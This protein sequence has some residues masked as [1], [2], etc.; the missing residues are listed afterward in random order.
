VFF[1]IIKVAALQHHAAVPYPL[2]LRLGPM[3]ARAAADAARRSIRRH[4]PRRTKMNASSTTAS[5]ECLICD[6]DGVLVDSE[7]I[8]DRVLL[9]M[10]GETFT[11][12][13][14]APAVKLSFGQQTDRFVA[15]LA[16]SFGLTIPADFLA[17][18]QV[19]VDDELRRAVEPIDGVRAA[20]EQV[21]LPLAV[22][23]NSGHER[24][25]ISLER[26]GLADLFGDRIFSA[27]DVA[28]PKPFPDVYLHAA[29]TLGASPAR[30]LV[31]EDS[32]AGLSAART[33]GM[34]TIAFIGAAH[35][36]PGY[37]EQ[38][39]D[40]GIGW[41]ID[42]MNALPPLTEAAMRGVFPD[43]DA[44]N[45]QGAADA[46]IAVSTPDRAERSRY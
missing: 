1:R 27:E 43:V 21:R 41:I 22:A 9:Q 29:R 23:S 17:R 16:N 20:L 28:N 32:V 7:A 5:V 15:N 37:R 42:R 18:L 31:L 13:D 33:A 36:P 40:M 3:R 10:L 44:G 34:R 12:I 45:A 30:C 25:A 4:R 8:A 26:A 24:V 11:G 19:R 46:I 6:C 39:R 14:F 35:I 2:F 38:L